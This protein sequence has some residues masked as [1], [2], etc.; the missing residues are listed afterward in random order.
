MDDIYREQFMDI[1]K[2]PSNRGKLS[3]PSEELT[4]NNPMCGDVITMQLKLNG[5]IIEDIKFDG[6]ACAVS[7]ASASIL[8]DE[9]KG[10]SIDEA[11]KI[12]K[13]KLLNMLGVELTTSRVKCA[14]LPLDTL[15]GML[16]GL[17]D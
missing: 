3:E 14:M 10:K 8:T 4:K 12:D 7:I 9:V 15:H 5:G 11:L 16:E 6:S 17:E 13:E 2:N 1:F